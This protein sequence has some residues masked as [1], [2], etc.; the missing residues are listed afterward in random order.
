MLLALL[1]PLRLP[2]PA[3]MRVRLIPFLMRLLLQLLLLWLVAAAVVLL[4]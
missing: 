1:L 3:C 4:L 2:L